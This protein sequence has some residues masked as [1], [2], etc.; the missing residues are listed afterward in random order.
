VGV[1]ALPQHLGAAQGVLHRLPEH[2][3]E[4]AAEELVA[5]VVEKAHGVLF[6]R[7]HQAHAV[8]ELAA[9]ARQRLVETRQVFG[10]HGQVGVQNH[11]DIA[12]GFGKTQPHGVALP[13]AGLLQQACFALRV[14][15]NC[16]GNGSVGVVAGMP[17]HE[18]QFGAAA[19][20][21]HT[22]KDGRDVAG[23]VARRNDDR[24]SG[25]FGMRRRRAAA[26]QRTRQ[27]DVRQRQVVKGPPAHQEAVGKARQ[28]G[29]G[30]RR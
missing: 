20:F 17:F 16:G 12:A 21:G 25:P 2:P 26:G 27:R 30:Q 29:E 5:Q 23:F 28:Q 3:G 13:H 14:G 1:V 18:N 8:D 4:H 19:H 24:H 22:R 9:S 7:V 10:R 11:Q 15:G 6:H